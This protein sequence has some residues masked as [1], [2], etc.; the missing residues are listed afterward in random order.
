MVYETGFTTEV[1]KKHGTLPTYPT[2]QSNH[3]KYR[4][5]VIQHCHIMKSMDNQI[6]DSI[7]VSSSRSASDAAE[8]DPFHVQRSVVVVVVAGGGRVAGAQRSPRS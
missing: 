4:K 7:V 2:Y 3:T 8:D 5:N 6:S 1:T